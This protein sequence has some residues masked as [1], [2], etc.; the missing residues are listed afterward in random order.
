MM[1][2]AR[3][4]ET[5][6]SLSTYITRLRETRPMMKGT[7]LKALG[8]EEGPAIG[9]M[10]RELLKK[11]LDNEIVTKEEEEALVKRE[12]GQKKR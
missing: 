3:N 8:V 6:R 5:R 11:R 7:D 4:D 10:L 12:L 2:K 9:E 1:A